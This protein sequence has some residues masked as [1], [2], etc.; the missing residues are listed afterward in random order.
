[1]LRPIGALWKKKK[2][3]NSYLS[4]K[5]E[6]SKLE[7]MGINLPNDLQILVFKNEKQKENQPDYRIQLSIP[8]NELPPV[9]QDR[10]KD[11]DF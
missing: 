8:D 5:I 9:S 7:E 2:G 11:I 1:M 6:A 4:G 3:D 10:G